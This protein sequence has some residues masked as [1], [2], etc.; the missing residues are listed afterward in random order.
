MGRTA[1]R[2]TSKKPRNFTT[3]EDTEE[4]VSLNSWLTKQGVC[5]NEKLILANF[6]D[7]GRGVL[8]KRKIYPGEEFLNM[9]LNVT[10]NI[11]TV[12]MDKHF[13]S[14]FLENQRNCFED[15][16]QKLSFQSL[17]AF[18][19]VYHKGLQSK[20]KWHLYLKSLP[21][22]YTVPYFLP[23]E[24]Q[25][26][27]DAKI[28]SIISKQGDVIQSSYSIF[29][30]ILCNN[31]SEDIDLKKLRESF[32]LKEYEW[33]YFT[34]NT[35]CVFM[36]LT[37]LV[38]V[39]K[40]SQNQIINLLNDDTKIALCPYL[41]MINH[42]PKARN[43]TKLILN[44]YTENV[45]VDNVT[46]DIFTDVRFSIYTNNNFDPYTQIFIC[47]GDS[48]NLKLLTEYGF[49]L[50]NN[51]LDYVA[52]EFETVEDYL[53]TK[54]LKLSQ[55]QLNF[56][57]N[58]SL[59]KDLYID[60]KGLSFNFYALLMVVKCYYKQNSDVSKIIYSSMDVFSEGS[61][62][63]DLVAPLVRDK[64]VNIN[65]CIEN[66]N[67]Y[68]RKECVILGNCVELMCQYVKILEKFI[69]C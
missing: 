50:P 44:K 23:K 27:L 22:Q 3:C 69:K 4:V 13:H 53:K 9:P 14:V 34:V 30:E 6:D 21:T 60:I 57:T 59:N 67:K 31:T 24:V 8:T 26:Y 28:L 19:L 64:I 55:D 33:A 49:I 40:Q 2:R 35:R 38:N 42:S 56:I 16:R 10:I 52:F 5:R 43:E 54:E 1:R 12:L 58:H 61:S 17:L 7:I 39:K 47:Y 48:Y 29:E 32:T 46:S 62:F 68:G 63:N 41:D 18:Y 65:E 51:E 36:D 37:K 25:C 11:T 45:S 20:S 15:Y 66:L